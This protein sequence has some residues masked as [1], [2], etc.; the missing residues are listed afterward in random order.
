LYIIQERLIFFPEKLAINYIY[1]FQT[2]FNEYFLETKD[3]K[4]LNLLHF[5]QQKETKSKGVIFYI[6]G[7]SKSLKYWGGFAPFFLNLGYDFVCFDYRGFGKSEGKITSQTQLFEDASMVYK[8]LEN[9]YSNDEIIIDGYS[10]GSGI[11]AY[12]AINFRA[13]ILIL[14]A[15]YY[16]LS[17]IMRKRYSI[18]PASILRYKFPTNAYLAKCKIP[19]YI[20]HG[21]KD[22]QISVKNSFRLNHLLKRND[23]LFILK[24]QA[25]NDILSNMDYQ[26][27]MQQILA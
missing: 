2:P 3:G 15:P 8:W 11:A 16:R 13:K 20:F 4:K 1:T 26:A 27:E 9:Q 7:N 21:E 12:L 25:H 10:I 14:E 6:H 17:H 24:N 23:K 19:V 22:E 18:F 5:L